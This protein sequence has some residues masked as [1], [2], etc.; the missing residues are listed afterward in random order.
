MSPL[1]W[2]PEVSI[3]TNKASVEESEGKFTVIGLKIQVPVTSARI[4][5]QVYRIN[6]R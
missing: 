4:L 2:N 6:Q 3:S 1:E 5:Y